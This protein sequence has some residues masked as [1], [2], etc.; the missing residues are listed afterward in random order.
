LALFTYADG[1]GELKEGTGV[2]NSAVAN[3]RAFGF[4]ALG[5]QIFIKKGTVSATMQVASAIGA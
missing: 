2:L 5:G 3:P 1:F 4:F